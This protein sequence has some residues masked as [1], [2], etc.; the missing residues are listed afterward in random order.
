M[1]KRLLKIFITI[2][3]L[4]REDVITRLWCPHKIKNITLIDNQL[5]KWKKNIDLCL[6]YYILIKKMLL[7]LNIFIDLAYKLVCIFNR[8]YFIKEIK[9][10]TI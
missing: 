8:L 7:K 4:K 9:R 1:K 6:M 5:E 10:K 2:L 3:K